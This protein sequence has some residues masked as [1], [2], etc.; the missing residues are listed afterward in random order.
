MSAFTLIN[1]RHANGT[2]AY[3]PYA[4]GILH[5]SEDGE[6]TDCGLARGYGDIVTPE[7]QSYGA[8]VVMSCEVCYPSE[9]FIR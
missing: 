7:D 9:G 1:C 4:G 3:V 8:V 2:P 5:R 6:W